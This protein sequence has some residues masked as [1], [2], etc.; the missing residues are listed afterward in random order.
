MKTSKSLPFDR[1]PDLQFHP[2][3]DLCLDPTVGFYQPQNEKNDRSLELSLMDRGMRKPF[4]ATASHGKLV[5]LDGKRRYPMMLKHYGPDHVIPVLVVNMVLTQDEMALLQMDLANT[6]EK[7]KVDLVSEFYLYDKHVPK[8]Q[9]KKGDEKIDRRKQIA[10][11]M[12]ISTSHLALLLMIDRI[13]PKLL[14]AVDN[15][16]ATLSKVARQAK[17]IQKQKEAEERENKKPEGND[18]DVELLKLLNYRDKVIDIN[19][20]ITCCPTCRHDLD[21]TWKEI[22]PLFSIGRNETNSATD[23]LRDP[24]KKSIKSK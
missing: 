8:Q 6:R 10:E 15:G 3:A 1:Q 16:V 5:I 4:I 21:R 12:D 22:P 19:D 20:R 2:L 23:W 7:L 18:P 11:Y 13:N 9:G 17:A 24:K 14:A